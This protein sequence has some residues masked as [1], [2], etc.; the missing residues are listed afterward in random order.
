MVVVCLHLD[1]DVNVLVGGRRRTRLD[2]V[3]RP[4]LGRRLDTGRYRR[5]RHGGLHPVNTTS[6]L[7]PV[8]L[9]LSPTLLSPRRPH[10]LNYT[11]QQT[12]TI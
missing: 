6:C 5:R 11:T 4:G 2:Q 12:I 10:H 1:H 8:S 9:L 3:D 7:A